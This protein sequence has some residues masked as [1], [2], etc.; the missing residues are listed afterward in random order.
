MPTFFEYVDRKQRQ[1]VRQLKI[2]KRIL[3]QAG[4]QVAS[5]LNFRHKEEPYLYVYNPNSDTKFGLRVYGV[6]EELAYRLQ[7]KEK[8]HPYG[9]PN[10]LTIADMWDDIKSEGKDDAAAANE[11][12]KAVGDEITDYFKQSAKAEKKSSHVRMD[13]SPLGGSDPNNLTN[14]AIDIANPSKLTNRFS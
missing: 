10:R 11:I 1:V 13:Q 8:T 4:L 2:V 5:Q 6:G 9:K 3:G 12:I 14:P 7:R